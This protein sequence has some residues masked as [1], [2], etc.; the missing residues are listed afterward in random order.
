VDH[1]VPE[2]AGGQTEFD[3]LCLS[4]H[5]CNEFKGAQVASEDPVT[6]DSVALYH[7]RHQNWSDNF[8]WSPDGTEV[9]GITPIG[10]ATLL[11]LKMNHPVI[12]E[13]RRLWVAVGWHP[14]AE[15]L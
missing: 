11:A 15:D 14:P 12:I 5:S 9:V 8:R 1:I 2:A 4:C 3:N 13:A 10:R 7:P 6:G